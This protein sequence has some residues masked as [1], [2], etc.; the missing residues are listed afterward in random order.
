MP[1]CLMNSNTTSDNVLLQTSFMLLFLLTYFCAGDCCHTWDMPAP[2]IWNGREHE[3]S[4]AAWDGSMGILTR[5]VGFFDCMLH[6]NTWG[7]RGTRGTNQRLP[8]HSGGANPS[9]RDS[10]IWTVAKHGS[11]REEQASWTS[12]IFEPQMKGGGKEM[13]VVESKWWWLRQDGSASLLVPPLGHYVFPHFS[14][15][16]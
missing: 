2:K 7:T 13:V 9:F 16:H 15:C 1:R 3:G 8:V 14:G 12:V 10:F 11:L 6:A 5:P 4:R